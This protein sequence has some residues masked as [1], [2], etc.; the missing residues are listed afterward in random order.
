[1]PQK[2]NW[3]ALELMRAKYHELTSA[4]LQI[5]ATIASLPSGYNRDFQLLKPVLIKSFET[6]LSS[7][8]IATL[9]ITSLKVDQEKIAQHIPKTLFAAHWAYVVMQQKNIPFRK[10]YKFVKN[11][12]DEIPN[13]DI[14]EV[15][16]SSNSQGAP[17][18]L[19]LLHL[20]ENIQI[21]SKI[22]KQKQKKLNAAFHALS[23]KKGLL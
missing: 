9:F 12:L 7:L 19:G 3:D 17:G 11:H 10:A 13:F 20:E 2:Q 15:L 6:V 23:G 16:R 5:N 18:N 14:H 22:W 1:M 4:Q 8:Q 21:Q